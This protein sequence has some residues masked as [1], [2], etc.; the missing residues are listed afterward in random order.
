MSHTLKILDRIIDGRSREEVDIG[1]EQ[2]GFMKGSGTSDGIFCLSQ[3]AVTRVR[4]SVGETDGLEA[5]VE[6]HQGSALS[7]FIFNIVMD[8][9]TRNVRKTVLWSILIDR[10][11]IRMDREELK[12]VQKVKYL[13]SIVDVS[14]NLDEE[15]KH[16]VQAE[17]NNCTCYMEQKQ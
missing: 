12:R 9:M 15:V 14:G 3:N 4:S 11:S 17:W 5:K 16:R 2:L 10:G 6:L 8:V 13:G 1:K 7:P